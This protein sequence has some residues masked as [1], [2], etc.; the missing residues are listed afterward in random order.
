[1]LFHRKIFRIH[2]VKCLSSKLF[3]LASVA[4][5]ISWIA[6]R[7]VA[8][9][10][11]AGSS[12][13]TLTDLRVEYTSTPLGMDVLS[14]RFSWQM[15]APEGT[16]GYAQTAYRIKVTDPEGKVEWDTQK[17]VSEVSLGIHYAGTPLEAATRYHWSLKVWDQNGASSSE[18]SWFETGLMN[19]DGDLAAWDGAEWIGGG[20]EDLVFFSHYLS[21]LKLEYNLQLDRNSKSTKAAFVFGANDSRLMDRNKN[22]YNIESAENESY[23]KFE[24]DISQ[25]DGTEN[26]LA[27]LSIYRVGYHPEDKPGV[28]FQSYEIPMT[29]I[30][31][32]NKYD[33]HHIYAESVFGV[34]NIFLNGKDEENKIIKS[35]GP[36]LGPFSSDGVNLNPVGRGGDYICFPMLAEIGFSVQ[37]GQKAY[38]SNIKVTNYRYPSNALF[39]GCPVESTS[40]T[41]IDSTD[42]FQKAAINAGF[43]LAI[44]NGTYVLDGGP[45]GY[46]LVADPSRNSMPML[47]TEFAAEDKQID[48]ARLYVTARGIYEIYINGERIGWDY[49]NPGLTQYNIT[50]MY[51]TYDV[52]DLIDPGEENAMGAI[53]GEGWWS[54]NIT[55]SGE[56]WNCFGD[57][58]S[59]LA[60]LV[61]TYSDGSTGVVVTNNRDWKYYSN[62]PVIYGSFFQGEVYDATREAAIEGWHSPGYDD[63]AWKNAMEVPLEGTAFRGEAISLDGVTTNFNYDK[64]SLIGQIGENARVVDTLTAQSMEEVRPGVYVYD[65]GQNMVGVPRIQIDGDTAGRKVTMRYAEVRYPELP[66]YRDNVGMIMIENIRAALAQDIY[67][68][69]GG[70]EIIQPRFT[71]HGYRFIEITGI[72]KAMP[73]DA[74]QGLVISSI[75]ELNAYYKTSNQKVNRLW[76]NIVWS[77]RGNFLSIPT[78]CPQRNERMGWS[79]D[80]SVFSRTATYVADVD[81]FLARHMRAMRDLQ[82]DNGW[83]SDVAPIGNGFGGIL[84]GSAGI[85]VAWEIYQQYGD[86]GLLLDHYDAMKRYLDYLS[87]R[88]D[89]DTGV[90]NEGPLGD[91]L[92]PEGN[93]NDNSLLWCAYYIYDLEI[94]A[95]IAELLGKSE[96]AASFRNKYQ[97]RKAHF[98]KTYVDKDTRK[99]M[100]SKFITAGFG[101]PG[102]VAS[103]PQTPMAGSSGVRELIDTQ[104]SYA[105]PLALGVFSDENI[106]YAAEHL[107]AACS[108]P[109]MDDS[110]EIRPEYSLMTGFIG[111]AWIS[112]ALS[113]NGYSDI[114]YRLLQQDSYPSWLYPVD[115]GSTTIWERLNSFTVEEGFGGNNSMNSFNHYSFGAV[116]SWMMAHSL[117]IERDQNS[118]GFKHFILKPEPDHTGEMTWAKGYYDSICGRISSAWAVN[119]GILTYETTV[120]AN[121][122]ATLYLPAASEN[123]VTENGKSA[124]EAEGVTFISFQQGKA[125]YEVKS[126]SYEFSSSL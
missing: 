88:I 57:R 67:I 28:P 17:V 7:A 34:I 85:T 5:L 126:G 21:V 71:F 66:E 105:V 19:A 100:K 93:K 91:W 4:L 103:D 38:F 26:G 92:S 112:K 81:Q 113:E 40:K 70:E 3:F 56:N 24:L 61:I 76:E 1:M 45:N 114:A 48:G 53:L 9:F 54:G 18:T 65:M 49:F 101:P 58:Q 29:L 41:E 75:G 36:N 63:S 8:P 59:L 30:N 98:N 80:I 27:R 55:F 86:K 107:A 95:M 73:L 82:R 50:H 46:F 78:D 99:T 74:V 83:F 121:T 119:N 115:Q 10:G 47:R 44:D 6:S 104:V 106:S 94:M 35:D 111:T 43:G 14:P 90:V 12:G 23:I 97:E 64:F 110:G 52:T 87:T 108:R 15:I 62:G 72:E 60:K 42:I 69:K 16:R 51:Q 33:P 31:N 109:N 20:P 39:E 13:V 102:A 37:S 122:T 22:I 79:G 2:P 125:V 32:D 77:T 116:G 84:W 68:L 124:A 89:P 117:G 96:D 25:V 123:A 118:P 120:P 11:S